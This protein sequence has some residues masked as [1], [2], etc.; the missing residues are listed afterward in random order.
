MSDNSVTSGEAFCA[1]P[2]ATIKTRL[3]L[4]KSFAAARTLVSSIIGGG[5][6]D[7]RTIAEIFPRLPQISIA[8]SRAAGPGR[9]R[10][11]DRIAFATL[12]DASSGFLIW[13][14]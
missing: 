13:N 11:M 1:P 2:P 10:L 14:E 8:H 6:G 7:G 12:M 5:G 9:P 3:A 4:P